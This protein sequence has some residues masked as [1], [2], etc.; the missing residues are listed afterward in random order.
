MNEL[1]YGKEDVV[2][3]SGSCYNSSNGNK[4]V[5]GGTFNNNNNEK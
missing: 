3:I 5:G 1:M 2:M 4:N